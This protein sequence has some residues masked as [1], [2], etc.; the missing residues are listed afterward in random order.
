MTKCLVSGKIELSQ[1]FRYRECESDERVIRAEIF[2]I[3]KAKGI[4]DF[5]KLA[6]MVNGGKKERYFKKYRKK[7]KFYHRLDVHFHEWAYMV[8]L[9]IEREWVL[10]NS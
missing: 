6:L 10:F 9:E 4:V 1:H 8:T 5:R 7:E 3:V 2:R